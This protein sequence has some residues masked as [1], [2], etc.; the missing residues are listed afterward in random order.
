M[1]I[2]ELIKSGISRVGVV[3][4]RSALNPFLWS[5]VWSLLFLGFAVVFREDQ[6][7]KYLLLALAAVPMVVTMAVGCFFAIRCPD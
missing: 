2:E 6:V 1:S 5:F 4:V 3:H 7:I